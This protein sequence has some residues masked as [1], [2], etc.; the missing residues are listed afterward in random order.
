MRLVACIPMAAIMIAAIAGCRSHGYRQ[1]SVSHLN[2]PFVSIIQIE[3]LVMSYVLDANTEYEQI[4][5]VPFRSDAIN[6]APDG[7]N[8][9]IQIAISNK[10]TKHIMLNNL[11]ICSAVISASA[12]DSNGQKWAFMRGVPCFSYV[13]SSRKVVSSL[14]IKPGESIGVFVCTGLLL[15]HASVIQ[16]LDRPEAITNYINALPEHLNVSLEF[17]YTV[18]D[19]ASTATGVDT[20]DSIYTAVHNKLILHRQDGTYHKIDDIDIY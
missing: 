14:V 13:D 18:L 7:A 4:K 2:S 1:S 20:S 3:A 5:W 6:E 10:G 17:A 8:A 16:A 15:K 19:N 11:S 12:H 9:V